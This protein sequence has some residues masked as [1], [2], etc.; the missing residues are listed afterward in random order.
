MSDTVTP[1]V[2]SKFACPSCRK[3]AVRDLSRLDYASDIQ[4][5]YCDHCATWIVR[6]FD[7]IRWSEWMIQR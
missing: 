5:D 2:P 4:R 6:C 3:S 7:G 1:V